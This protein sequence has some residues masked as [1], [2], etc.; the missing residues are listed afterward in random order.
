MHVDVENTLLDQAAI[1]VSL[2]RRRAPVGLEWEDI[3]QGVRLRLVRAAPRYEASRGALTTFFAAHARGAV[4][5]ALGTIG[6][7][8]STNQLPDDMGAPDTRFDTI[9]AREYAETL[10][11]QLYGRERE[12][13][14]LVYLDGLTQ[15]AAGQLLGIS[16]GLA[17]R[18]VSQAMAK[19]R[20]FVAREEVE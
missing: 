10:I 12:I 15:Y 18:N 16:E 7:R 4:L 9:D 17:S 3:E 11:A 14:R 5:D 19:L 1:A 8:R 2:M 6:H 20:Q 13:M